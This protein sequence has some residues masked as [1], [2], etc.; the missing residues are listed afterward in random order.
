MVFTVSKSF[1]VVKLL[2]SCTKTYFKPIGQYQVLMVSGIANNFELETISW[3][4]NCILRFIFGL[5]K[6]ENVSKVKEDLKILNAQELHLYEL[7][8]VLSEVLRQD[9]PNYFFERYV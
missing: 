4:Q 3:W 9:S 7:I 2:Y 5:C 1:S 6:I 8:K